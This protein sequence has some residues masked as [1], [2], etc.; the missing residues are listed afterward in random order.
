MRR[1]VPKPAL[2]PVLKPAPKP[3]LKPV[4]KPALKPVLKPVLKA[5]PK[6]ALK[7]A[8][9]RKQ[10]AEVP[11]YFSAFALEEHSH[12]SLSLSARTHVESGVRVLS[13]CSRTL[14]PSGAGRVVPRRRTHA[15]AARYDISQSFSPHLRA[16]SRGRLVSRGGEAKE[17]LYHP[18]PFLG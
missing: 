14:F 15:A 16:A 2:K 8:V 18:K 9:I 3:V 6:P 13:Q 1:A 12:L 17:W 7:A 5:V 11:D 4:L 10:R